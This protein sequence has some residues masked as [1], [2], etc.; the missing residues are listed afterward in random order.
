MPKIIIINDPVDFEPEED[1]GDWRQV[2][3]CLPADLR[4][5]LLGRKIED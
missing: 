3:D 4:E 5:L 1:L 2:A